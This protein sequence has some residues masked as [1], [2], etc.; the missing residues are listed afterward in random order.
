MMPWHG[1]SGQDVKNWNYDN[2][3]NLHAIWNCQC[4]TVESCSHHS[5]TLIV[6][7][8][9]VSCELNCSPQLDR[10]LVWKIYRG[11]AFNNIIRSL[12]VGSFRLFEFHYSFNLLVSFE[13]LELFPI[14]YTEVVQSDLDNPHSLGWRVLSQQIV[15]TLSA[16]KQRVRPLV[17]EDEINLINCKFIVSLGHLI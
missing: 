6:C 17:P 3:Y 10:S 14:L 13:K 15:V 1:M 7:C 5:R 4:F 2:S 11:P 12:L 9:S 8:I 16:G